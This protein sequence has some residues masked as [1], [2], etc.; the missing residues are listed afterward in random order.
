[1][2]RWILEVEDLWKHFG[3]LTAVSGYELKLPQGA[4]YGL[5]GPN[6]AGKTTVFNLISGVL[7]P[8]RGRIFF[9]G[10]DITSLRPDTI[11]ALGLTRTF[12]NLR[13][14]PSLTV[15]ENLKIAAHIHVRCGFLPT[16]F[17]APSFFRE[18]AKVERKV[19]AML[20]RFGMYEFRKELA[21]NLPYGLQRKLDI[22]RALMTEPEL[23]LLDEPSAGM[24]TKEADDLA[25]LVAEIQRD[26]NLTM[27]IVEHRMSFV[28]GLAEVIQVLDHGSIIATGTPEEIRTNPRVIEAYLGTGDLVA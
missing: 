21:S 27:I 3:G 16:L 20:E 9:K 11:T 18:E 10:R 22:A 12:Q 8:S 6:G 13:L 28:M 1:M 14:F 5:I 15:E 2:S 19:G 23:V 7:K 24:N 4:I 26:L 17:C 25:H